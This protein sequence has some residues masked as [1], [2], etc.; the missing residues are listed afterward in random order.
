MNPRASRIIAA[1]SVMFLLSLVCV[2]E[3]PDAPARISGLE[4]QVYVGYQYTRYDY[5]LVRTFNGT[6]TAPLT[7]LTTKGVNVEYAYRKLNHLDLVSSFRFG[8]G[9]PMAEKMMTFAGGAGVF[10]QVRRFQPFGRLL[11]GYSHL[12]SNDNIYLAGGPQGGFATMF[13]AGVD[14]SVNNRWGVRPLYTEL[15]SLPFGSR[16]STHW[17]FGA[18]AIYRFGRPGG[19]RR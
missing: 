12:S 8:T 3:T 5:G 14:V 9:G 2:A 6:V 11:I 7:Q 17:N 1:L 10:L 15:Q 18:G 4:D 13:G 16:G 19:R